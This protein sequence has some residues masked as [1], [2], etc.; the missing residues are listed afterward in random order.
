MATRGHSLYPDAR[1]PAALCSYLYSCYC[2]TAN[3]DRREVFLEK[4]DAILNHSMGSNLIIRFFG[5]VIFLFPKSKSNDTV[6]L[7]QNFLVTVSLSCL[8]NHTLDQLSKQSTADVLWDFNI[9]CMKIQRIKKDV[10]H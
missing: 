6:S 8:R 9:A 10:D 2:Y 5:G 1:W 3:H 4:T 7:N